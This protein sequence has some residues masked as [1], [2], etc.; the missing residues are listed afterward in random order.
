MSVTEIEVPVLL[1]L[2]EATAMV[3]EYPFALDVVVEIL[4][5]RLERAENR[6]DTAKAARTRAWLVAHDAAPKPARKTTRKLAPKPAPIL[7]KTATR[8]QVPPEIYAAANKVVG[9]VRDHPKAGKVK[10]FIGCSHWHQ[11]LREAGRKAYA[12]ANA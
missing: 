8:G 1:T 11:A 2:A 12:E 9:V 3:E 10:C 6:G 7:P 5:T 4:T